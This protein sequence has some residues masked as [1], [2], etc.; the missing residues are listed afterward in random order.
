MIWVTTRTVIFTSSML[1]SWSR[2]VLAILVV[3]VDFPNVAVGEPLIEPERVAEYHKRMYTFPPASYVPNTTGWSDLM[4]YRLGQVQE[5]EDSG[6]RYEAYYQV[7]HSAMLTPNF[8]E[9]GF[10]LGVRG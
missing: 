9:F 10:A 2:I 6:R 4:G 1:A 3:S 7:M 5:I 8:T